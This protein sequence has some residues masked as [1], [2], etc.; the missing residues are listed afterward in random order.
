MHVI[1]DTREQL[2]LF[3][4][5]I[6]PEITFLNKKLDEGDYTTE[7]LKNIITVDRK[8]P[9][10]L[11]GSLFNKKNHD[12]F[13]DVMLRC[14]FKNIRMFVFVECSKQDFL[15]K[16]YEGGWFRKMNPAAMAKTI[17]TVQEKYGCI[18]VWCNGRTDMEEKLLKLFETYSKLHGI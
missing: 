2:P 8:A 3:Q 12:R 17:E 5:N 4:N 7:E 18:F 1:I 10:D 14:R 11:F 13:V 6:Y 9:G 15:S 16:N